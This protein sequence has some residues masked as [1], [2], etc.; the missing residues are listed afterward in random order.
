MFKSFDLNKFAGVCHQA[1]PLVIWYGAIKFLNKFI[2]SRI[3]LSLSVAPY[4][5]NEED[6]I[7]CDLDRFFNW[8]FIYSDLNKWQNQ[9]PCID[10]QWLQE[11]SDREKHFD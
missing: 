6:K 2:V 5:I 9:I 7:K 4:L 3:N 8:Y 10:L 1:L 11:I